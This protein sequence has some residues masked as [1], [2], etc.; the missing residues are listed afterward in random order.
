MLDAIKK[1]R[2]AVSSKD[3]IPELTYYLVKNG[4]VHASNGH[5]TAACP[6]PDDREYVVPAAMFEKFLQAAQQPKI[7]IKEDGSVQVSSK[8]F[9]AKIAPLDSS[10][11]HYGAPEG[12]PIVLGS[13]FYEGLRRLRP[14]VSD[15]ATQV[16]ATSIYV[17]NDHLYATN[18]VVL[19]RTTISDTGFSGLLPLFAVDFILSRGEAPD[20]LLGVDHQNVSFKWPDGSWLRTQLLQGQFPDAAMGM[21][22]SLSPASVPVTPEWF[23]LYNQVAQFCEGQVC[24]GAERIYNEQGQYLIESDAATPVDQETKWNPKFLTDVLTAA[25]HWEPNLWPKPAAFSGENLQGIIV[26]RN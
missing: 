3:I 10:T 18:N 23:A 22:D 13:D 16:W 26:G 17:C 15:N 11:L 8:S 7:T 25:T 24:I 14:F 19:A 6:C 4:Y 21:L 12:D 20:T 5:I 1:V 2:G 9:R